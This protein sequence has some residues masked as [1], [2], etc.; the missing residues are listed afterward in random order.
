LCAHRC[1]LLLLL[2]LPLPLQSGSL[3]GLVRRLLLLEAVGATA[4]SCSL[5]SVLL[6]PGVQ[7]AWQDQQQINLAQLFGVQRESS[8]S[9]SSGAV[10]SDGDGLA[11]GTAAGA[12]V[13]HELL[14]LLL[15]QAFEDSIKTLPTPTAGTAASNTCRSKHGKARNGK[16]AA[17]STAADADAGRLQASQDSRLRQHIQHC[18]VPRCCA[19]LT[20]W[21]LL[22]H[23]CVEEAGGDYSCA[24]TR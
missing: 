6:L 12:W 22:W 1:P 17:A 15:L 13:W 2:L 21:V 4:S 8:S 18:F 16:H 24:T 20:C 11:N 10:G 9:S 5:I 19:A 23:C 14:H 7:Q 3:A